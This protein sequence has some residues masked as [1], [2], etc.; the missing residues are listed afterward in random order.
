MEAVAIK[1]DAQIEPVDYRTEPSR[2]KHWK[3]GF[4]GEVAT[5]TL[6]ID[7]DGGIRPGYKLKLN[8]YDLG[9]DIELHDALQRIRFE[10][11]EVRTVVFT[12][13]K[14]KIF[15]SGANIY[16]LGVSTHAW[17]VN[18]C[19]FTNETRNGIE[20]ASQYSGLKFIAACNGT[21]AGGG[22]ELAL[23]CDEIVLVDDRNSAVSLPEV[24]L[25]GVL[26]GTG[27]LTRVTDKRKVRRDHADIFCTIS[28]GVRGSRAKDWKLVDDVVKQQQFGEHIAARAKELARQSNRPA[29]AKGVPLPRLERTVDDKGYHYEFVDVAIDAAG[30][31]A[32]LTVRAP[33]AVGA[34]SAAE[35]EA[36]GAAWWPLKMA[37]ELDDA[38][39]NLRTNHLDVGLWQLRTAGDAKVVLE[40][41]G[42]I[43]ANQDNWFVRE[44]LGMLR[45]TLA[46]IDVSSRSLYALIEPGSCFAGTLL[47]IALAADRS[48]MLDTPD[49]DNRIGLSA[50]NFGALPMV[51]GLSRIAARFYEDEAQVGAVKAKEGSLLTP[52]EAFEVGLVTS[53]PDDLDWA[54]E[55]RIAI[56]ERVALSPDALTGLEANLRFGITETMNTRI[57]GRLSAWQNWIFIRPNAVGANGAL[58]LFGSGKKAQF[59][60][61]RV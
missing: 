20:D 30:R 57:F 16:M 15:C 22:Y 5:L 12:S 44:T 60:W 58:K 47:E 24:P 25:L 56:E 50:L 7:E 48:Y 17:K 61:D 40:I 36:Q 37:R 27:G 18:F 28:E 43:A 4:D 34:R 49:A 53:I 14:A 45:R 54:D 3:L 1:Q 35:I 8:S 32:T 52:A 38:I 55:I 46:R 33:A 39:L 29:G 31:S 19:K 51:N 21:T 59:D 10:H 13:G 26:P 2:Y 6:D 9:V 42:I 23:A 11:P 41:D